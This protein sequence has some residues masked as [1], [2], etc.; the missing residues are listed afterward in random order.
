MEHRSPD[1]FR[2][3]KQERMVVA[4]GAPFLGVLCVGCFIATSARFGDTSGADWRS[5]LLN[6]VF[7]AIFI[8]MF[9]AFLLFL[10]LV[11][12]WAVFCPR[13]TVRTLQYVRNHVWHA[14]CFFLIGFPVSFWIVYAVR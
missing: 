10:L 4:I 7:Q 9:V 5:K 13:W 14:L 3:D 2:S 6:R 8:E 1:R 12:V 11:F